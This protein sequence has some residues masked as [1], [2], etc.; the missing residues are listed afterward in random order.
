MIDSEENMS[1]KVPSVY[2]HYRRK[3]QSE[4]KKQLISET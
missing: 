4:N 1:Q 3:Y 2:K